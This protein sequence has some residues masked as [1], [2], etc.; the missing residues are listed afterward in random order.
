MS[1]FERHVFICMNERPA[2]NPRGCC[3]AR[4]ASD[5]LDAFKALVKER[6]LGATVRAQRSGC[7]DYCASGATVVVY[8]EGTWYGHVTAAD[9][10]EIVESHLVGGVPVARLVLPPDT[11]RG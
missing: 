6:G 8:P 11:R 4:G 1:F 10:P 9:V 3:A 5:V 7:L 2:D